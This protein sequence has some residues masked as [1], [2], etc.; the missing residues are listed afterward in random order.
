MLIVIV[1]G[2]SVTTNMT[3]EGHTLEVIPPEFKA[4]VHTTHSL[5][6]DDRCLG[7]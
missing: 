2:A 3:T 5:C 1:R 7:G 6:R 4:P